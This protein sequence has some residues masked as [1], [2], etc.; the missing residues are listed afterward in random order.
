M[1]IK[2]SFKIAFLILLFYCSCQK[3]DLKKDGYLILKANGKRIAYNECR[4]KTEIDN[5]GSTPVYSNTIYALT[6]DNNSDS[7]HPMILIY[8]YGNT[9]GNYSE[10]M[11]LNQ[12]GFEANI[13]FN[14]S[15][16]SCPLVNKN[17]SVN[18]NI[19]EYDLSKNYIKG[20]LTGMYYNYNGGGDYIDVKKGEF[21]A[22]G[23]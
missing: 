11:L 10:S 16:Y 1:K 15:I 12:S 22:R 17:M 8:F 19:E 14:S 21:V 20:N 18:L 23:E 9:T 3:L 13:H 4:F 6:R 5:S 2:T 7:I